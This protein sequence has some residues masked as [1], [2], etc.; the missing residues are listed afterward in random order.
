MPTSY[1]GATDMA[2][3]TPSAASI[4]LRVPENAEV[5]I[6]GK[7]TDE[8]GTERRFNLPA[9]DT[10]LTRLLWSAAYH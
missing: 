4:T 1:Y 5:W 6:Q 2:A 8:K 7:K 10:L 3:S 9:Q